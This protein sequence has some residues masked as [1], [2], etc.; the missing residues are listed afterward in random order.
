MRSVVTVIAAAESQD[1]TTLETVKAELGITDNLSDNKLLA[2][3]RQASSQCA[4]YCDRVFG[5]E[6]VEETFIETPWHNALK[7]RR[8]P[9]QLVNSV[10]LAES[11]LD[12]SEYIVDTEAGLIY[13]NPPLLSYA[14]YPWPGNIVVNYDAGYELLDF[15]PH[16]IERACLLL[17]SQYWYAAGRD[18]FLRSEEIPGVATYSYGFGSAQAAGTTLPPEVTALLDPY[19]ELC[20]A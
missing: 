2:Y 1:L 7:L 18:P 14:A 3:I 8:R 13:R 11:P 20:Y 19:R 6:T 17:V 15:L 10:E 4:S 12:P 5:L 9:I 16:A